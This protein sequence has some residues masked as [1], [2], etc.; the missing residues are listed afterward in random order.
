MLQGAK[1]AALRLSLADT[2]RLMWQNDTSVIV[3][4]HNHQVQQYA[5]ERAQ[6]AFDTPSTVVHQ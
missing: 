6:A 5:E 2:E 4:R 3:S 1:P